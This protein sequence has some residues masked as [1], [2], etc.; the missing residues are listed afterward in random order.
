MRV[1]QL[2]PAAVAQFRALSRPVVYPNGIL[3]TQLLVF[4]LSPCGIRLTGADI[5]P[6][7]YPRRQQV[8]AANAARM[9]ALPSAD[10]RTYDAQ[11][12]GKLPSD[13]RRRVL[14]G[15]M[16]PL[17]L[18]LKVDAQVMLIKNLDEELVNGT[19]G[20]VLRF[21]DAVSW[22][23]EPAPPTSRAPPPAASSA[24]IEWP[25]VQFQTAKG[26]S[27]QHLVGPELFKTQF[28]DGTLAASRT[29][30]NPTVAPPTEFVPELSHLFSCL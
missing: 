21:I 22:H 26:K 17:S 5:L 6:L 1:G 12:A 3:P 24:R 10:V 16:A 27:V 29:Q 13:Q 15:F 23:R 30:V 28:P 20:R 2:L 7:R 18:D 25:L 19:V 14:E 11:D 8:D 4:P 9:A